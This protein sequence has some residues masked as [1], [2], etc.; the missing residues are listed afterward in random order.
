MKINRLLGIAILLL[1]RETI[2]AKELA[3]RFGVSTRTIYRDIDVLSSAG[4]PVFTNKGNGGGISLLE[5]YS[6]NKTLISE[7][8]IES[9]LLALKTLKAAK[10]P[11][12]DAILEKIGAVFKHAET[13]WVHIDFSPWDSTPN[14]N[15]KFI[16]IKKAILERKRISFEYIN[17]AGEKS[18]RKIEPM[19]LVFK[20]QA[21]YLWGYCITKNDFRV[22]R[23]S[24]MKNVKATNEVFK[25]RDYTEK[26]TS[27]ETE[28]IR[29]L[30][31]LKL[32][33]Y[34]QAL[35][36]LYDDFDDEMIVKNDD[37]TFTVEVQFPE[38]E[39]VYGY[40]LSFGSYVEVLE[41]QHIRNIIAERAIKLLKFYEKM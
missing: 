23:I 37:G 36:R 31:R 32:K 25:R 3:G 21:W 30:T 6:L 18:S 39:W 28:N 5:N 27:D 15:N 24:R 29:P 1:N 34:P 10:Y 19:R 9:I 12:I 17:S 41:P 35:Y 22:F 16:E 20:G 40:L 26:N 13:D 2:T 33:F 8:E 14:E 11:E 4:V 7:N 38:D